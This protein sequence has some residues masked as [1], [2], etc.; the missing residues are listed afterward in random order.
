MENATQEAVKL[1]AHVYEQTERSIA[2][3]TARAERVRLLTS[4]I[5]THWCTLLVDLCMGKRGTSSSTLLASLTYVTMTSSFLLIMLL[6]CL[7]AVGPNL[8][9]KLK[10]L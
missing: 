1:K 5:F 8:W 7:C 9:K 3:A 4:L 2:D 10:I 6:V